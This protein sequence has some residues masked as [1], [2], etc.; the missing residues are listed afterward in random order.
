MA[1]EWDINDAHIPFIQEL[2]YD[3]FNEW[4]DGHVRYVYHPSDDH[5]RKHISGWAMR[6][7]N[8]H[9]VSILKKSC[10]GVLVCSARCKLPTGGHIHLRPA[11][12]DKARRKQQGRACPNRNCKAGRLEVLPCRGHCGYPVTHYWRHTEKA[13][14]FQAKGAHDHPQPESKTSGETRKIIGAG[15]KAAKAKKLSVLLLR[16]AAL[17]NKLMSLKSSTKSNGASGPEILQPPPLIPDPS[18]GD[19]TKCLSCTR[20]PCVCRTK[21]STSL[22]RAVEEN[23][24]FFDQSAH[25]Q[26]SLQQHHCSSAWSAYES[27]AGDSFTQASTGYDANG[28]SMSHCQTSSASSTPGC[29]QLRTSSLINECF[30]PDEIFQLDQPLRQQSSAGSAAVVSH[31]TTATPTT[32]LDLGSG[33]IYKKCNQISP[34]YI[35]GTAS[36]GTTNNGDLVGGSYQSCSYATGGGSAG[37]HTTVADGMGV[38]QTVTEQPIGKYFASDGYGSLPALDESPSKDILRYIKKEASTTA[39]Q[40]LGADANCTG[41]TSRT[42]RPYDCEPGQYKKPAYHYRPSSTAGT[43]FAHNN[44]N[45]NSAAN[46]NSI[47]CT[48]GVTKST[49]NSYEAH[50][51]HH[52]P[53]TNS[54]GVNYGYHGQADS[55]GPSVAISTGSSFEQPYG[56]S[57]YISTTSTMLSGSPKA[58]AAMTQ[59]QQHHHHHQQ[60]QSELHYTSTVYA[61]GTDNYRYG[62]NYLKGSSPTIHGGVPFQASAV[63]QMHPELPLAAYDFY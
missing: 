37:S 23:G 4:S 43:Y 63:Q 50:L 53:L 7:T 54:N 40:S 48:S 2:V 25:P 56:A 46:N 10:L 24:S 29:S 44:N 19:T 12:C 13:I 35:F 58:V 20:T 55:V 45:S 22:A 59:Q 15:G 60:H 32:L 34:E 9:N 42:T 16:D 30:H 17:G 8:N 51:D 38:G 14:F 26:P 3:K 11:I 62:N 52:H 27:A 5:A 33:A 57:S 47:I 18:Y 39:K 31:L 6:N 28:S 21:I 49:P 36:S 1:G 41:V 61:A